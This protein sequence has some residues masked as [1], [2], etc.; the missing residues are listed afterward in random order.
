MPFATPVGI[1]PYPG[2]LNALYPR[3]QRKRGEKRDCNAFTKG[4][5]SVAECS[6]RLLRYSGIVSLIVVLYY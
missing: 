4:C 3:V 6:R 2:V 5:A 1:H